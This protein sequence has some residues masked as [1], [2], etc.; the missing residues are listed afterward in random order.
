MIEENEDDESGL[1][2]GERD[3]RRSYEMVREERQMADGKK[4]SQKMYQ[5]QY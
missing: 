2:L 1:M 3:G 4:G 5:T